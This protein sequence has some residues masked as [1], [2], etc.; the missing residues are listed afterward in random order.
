MNLLKKRQGIIHICMCVHIHTYVLV[1]LPS[2]PSRLHP[3][4]KS[5]LSYLSIPAAHLTLLLA[6]TTF[7]YHSP[8]STYWVLF[9]LFIFCVLLIECSLQ[10][11]K[12][13]CKEYCLTHDT[14]SINIYCKC[15]NIFFQLNN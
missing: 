1:Y 4:V 9:V 7:P 12:D 14:F 11:D 8:L 3:V 13:S 2:L 6:C 10:E 15:I 5:C